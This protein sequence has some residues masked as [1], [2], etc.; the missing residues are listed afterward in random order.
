MNAK[1]IGRLL[2]DIMNVQNIQPKMFEGTS[3]LRISLGQ[4]KE[5]FDV[6]L[7]KKAELNLT[8]QF[9]FEHTSLCFTVALLQKN[10][11][12]PDVPLLD[13]AYV[14]LDDLIRETSN[15]HGPVIKPMYLRKG[16]RDKKKPVESITVKFAV[17]LFDANV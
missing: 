13:E 5:C 7:S 14:T 11:Y 6:D 4:A 10:L 16:I 8:T 15:H 17:Q 1:I 9:P 2:I 12:S 3:V